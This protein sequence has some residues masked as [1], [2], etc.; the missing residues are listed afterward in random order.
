MRVSCSKGTFVK[1]RVGSILVQLTV[2]SLIHL[3]AFSLIGTSAWQTVY[4]LDLAGSNT[5]PD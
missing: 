2:T 1:V 5:G 3:C 4:L